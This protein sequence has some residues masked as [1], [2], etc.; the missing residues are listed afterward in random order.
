MLTM[1]YKKVLLKVEYVKLVAR[2]IN[3]LVAAGSTFPKQNFWINWSVIK[4]YDKI[5]GPL[6]MEKFQPFK[7][8]W[9]Q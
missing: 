8:I 5:N 4:L 2:L 3:I 1:W 9:D 6:D 7:N